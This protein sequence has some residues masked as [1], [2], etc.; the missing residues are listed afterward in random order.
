[1][2]SVVSAG[3]LAASVLSG[4]RGGDSELPPVHLIHNMDT[5]EKAKA[6]RKDTTGLFADGRI[7]RAPVEGTVAVGQ[8]NDDD[9]YYKG[10]NDDGKETQKFPA[11]IVGDDGAPKADIIARGGQRYRIYC[12]PCHGVNGDGDG[13][14]NTAKG[15][16]VAPPAMHSERVKT[17]VNGKIFGAIT[18]G[19]NN[20]NMGS[21]AAQIPVEDR[22]AIAAW[23]RDLQRQKDPNQAWEVGEVVVADVKVASAEVG[24]ALY[25]AK[26][27]VGCHSIDGSRLVGPSFKGIWGRKEV[28]NKGPVTVDEAYVT[29]SIRMPMAKVVETYPPAMPPYDDKNIT[30]IQL[31]S[32]ILYFKTLN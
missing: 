11:S 17:L 5:Q 12:A 15:L 29:E 28:T 24:A 26:A 23:V 9:Q 18:Y 30:D 1:M 21:Y 32:I 20:G 25:K 27:C 8:L 22:W 7:M 31:Q 10:F 3:L 4:C 6:Y 16:L 14:V 13:T 19:V 2:R